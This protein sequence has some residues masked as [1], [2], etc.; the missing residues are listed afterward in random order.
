M[1]AIVYSFILVGVSIE[2]ITIESVLGRGLSGLSLL[3]L[4][5]DISRDMRTGKI[6]N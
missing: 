3:G 1:V 2:T 6:G 4:P 5:N